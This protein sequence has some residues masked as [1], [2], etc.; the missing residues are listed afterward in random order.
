MQKQKDRFSALK[1]IIMKENRCIIL[2]GTTDF[3]LC[4]WYGLVAALWRS[5]TFMSKASAN[6]HFSLSFLP[7]FFQCL[8][9]WRVGGEKWGL[10]GRGTT[11]SISKTVKVLWQKLRR[12]CHIA[13]YLRR[14]GLCQVKG[15]NTDL[16]TLKNAI[17][18][19]LIVFFG[20]LGWGVW[21]K[22]FPCAGN[23]FLTLFKAVWKVIAQV[24]PCP[25][26][27]AAAFICPLPGLGFHSQVV[28]SQST[29]FLLGLTAV[30]L[31]L[32]QL[33]HL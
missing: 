33:E 20:V 32:M 13:A 6:K 15:G 5:K 9:S 27:P 23:I 12:H 14:F 4:V 21:L 26:L 28:V 18:F 29:S 10:V 2:L 1:S 24:Y 17:T 3:I 7:Y 19:Y 30:L 31:D 16:I 8:W 11:D 22:Q 25:P